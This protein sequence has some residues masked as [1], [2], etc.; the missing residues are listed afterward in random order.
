MHVAPQATRTSPTVDMKILVIAADGNEACLPAIQQTLDYLGTPYSVYIA[1]KTPGGLTPDRL[2]NGEHGYYQGIIL[3]TGQ[4]VY[5]TDASS[6]S[7][8]TPQEWADLRSYE[9]RLGIREVNW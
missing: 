1:A 4:L 7:A 3:T 9:A 2:S 8:L 6:V 5:A